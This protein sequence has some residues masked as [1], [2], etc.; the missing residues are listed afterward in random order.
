MLLIIDLKWKQYIDDTGCG[1][2][3]WGEILLKSNE[4]AHKA[5]FF[6]IFGFSV[7]II[8][9]LIVRVTAQVIIFVGFIEPT[10]FLT[11]LLFIG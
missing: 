5:T 7:K 2:F 1:Q 4:E 6:Q 10:V 11:I 9:C 3:F 8:T